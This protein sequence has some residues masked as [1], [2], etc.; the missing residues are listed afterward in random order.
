LGSQPGKLSS[1]FCGR[2]LGK[3]KRM[4]KITDKVTKTI[5]QRD[6]VSMD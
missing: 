5:F 6:S 1:V 4:P 3:V 2:R